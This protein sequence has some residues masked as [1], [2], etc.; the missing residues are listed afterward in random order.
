MAYSARA[1][2]Q[3]LVDLI[4]TE[5]GIATFVRGDDLSAVGWQ[6][7]PGASTFVPYVLVEPI[8]GG[9]TEGTLCNPHESP[10][11]DYIIR[12]IGMSVAQVETVDDKVFAALTSTKPAAA[13]MVVHHL[14]PDVLGGVDPDYDVGP[15]H[16][17]HAPTRWRIFTTPA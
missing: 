17:Y 14:S 4:G 5:T 6:G 15:P 9:F 8:T 12:P 10:R 2:T 11:P 13:G 3:A 7:T 16:I 1:L